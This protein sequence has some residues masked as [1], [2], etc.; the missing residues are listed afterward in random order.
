[1]DQTMVGEDFAYYLQKAKGALL[2]LGIYNEEKQVIYPHHHPR[3]QVD[4]SVLWRGTA[5]Y[6]ILGFYLLFQEII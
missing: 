3:F 1:M 5:V 6:S 4:E 2:T